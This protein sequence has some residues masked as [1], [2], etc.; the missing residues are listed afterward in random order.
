MRVFRS[1]CVSSE[2]QKKA[3]PACR[4]RLC[5]FKNIWLIRD[6]ETCDDALVEIVDSEQVDKR[7]KLSRCVEPISENKK[8]LE[9]FHSLQSLISNLSSS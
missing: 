5:M 3:M 1:Y 7:I 8:R 2:D 9:T 4:H 6:A